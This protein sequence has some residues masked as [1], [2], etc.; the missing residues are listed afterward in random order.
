MTTHEEA[1]G[2][3]PPIISVVGRSGSGKTVFLEKLIAELKNRGLTVG[4]IKHHLHD[5]EI[6]QP[7]KDSWRHAQAGSDAVIISSPSK[8]ALIKRLEE[9]M[10]IDQLVGHYLRDLDLVLTEG[11]KTAAR[12]RIEVYRGE[13]SEGLVSAP[14]DLVAIVSDTRLDL[15]VPQF[16]LDDVAGVA[17]LITRRFLSRRKTDYREE[18]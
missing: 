17:D 9:E 14:E 7:G 12:Q 16:D 2:Q 1:E 10:R 13:H 11:Y 5:F 4:T 15:A 8:V 6:D 18:K 3:V